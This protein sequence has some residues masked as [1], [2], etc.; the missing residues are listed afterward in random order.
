MVKTLTYF[1]PSGSQ[2]RCMLADCAFST[3]LPGDARH[4]MRVNIV[5]VT[6]SREF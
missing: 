5:I 1:L 3:G 6:T 2:Q 4:W